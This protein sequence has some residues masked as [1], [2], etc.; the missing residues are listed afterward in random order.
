MHVPSGPCVGA[1]ALRPNF[2]PICRLVA[3]HL[4]P[5]SHPLEEG[6]PDRCPLSPCSPGFPSCW[7]FLA[8]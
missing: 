8:P 6:P 7:L 2:V 5:C 4:S 3:S 1:P